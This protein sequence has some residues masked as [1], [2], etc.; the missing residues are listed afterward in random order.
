MDEFGKHEE[1][2]DISEKEGMEFIRGDLRLKGERRESVEDATILR[3]KKRAARLAFKLHIDSN[4][5][6][7][8]G[9]ASLDVLSPRSRRFK[10]PNAAQIPFSGQDESNFKIVMIRFDHNGRWGK[11]RGIVSPLGC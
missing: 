8:E 9:P 7:R 1:N 4:F 10:R 5:R 2:I 3:R 11:Q 6:R